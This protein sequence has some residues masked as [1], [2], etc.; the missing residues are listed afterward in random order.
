MHAPCD[1][2][3]VV[4]PALCEE[5]G[6]KVDLEQEVPELVRELGV[7]ATDEFVVLFVPGDPFL[8][9]ALQ[10]DADAA[11]EDPDAK[12]ELGRERVVRTPSATATIPPRMSSSE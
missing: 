11:K 7:V 6:Q 5:E 2:L 1:R 8:E 4:S 10:A 3:Q 9:A 12:R